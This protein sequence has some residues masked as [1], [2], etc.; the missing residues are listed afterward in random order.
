MK[1]HI[2]LLVLLSALTML[3]AALT[4]S[5]AADDT[6]KLGIGIVDATGLRL[7]ESPSTDS[8]V[9]NSAYQD[10]VVVVLADCGEWYKVI[11]NLDVGY[12]YKEYVIF[13]AVENADLGEAEVN[14][15]L[16]NL[17]AKPNSSAEQL[18]QLEQGETVNIIGLNNGWYK[19]DYITVLGWTTG[20]IRSDL[21]DLTEYPYENRASANVPKF[22]R[23]GYSIG[24][25]PSPAA[26]NGGSTSQS[27]TTSSSSAGEA[28]V[29]KAKEY[30]GVPYVYGGSSPSGFDCSGYVQYVMRACGYTIGRGTDSQYFDGPGTLV[31]KDELI[32]GD[33]VFFAG[34]YDTTG[35]SHV[36]IYIGDGNFIHSSSSGCVKITD[37]YSSYYVEHYYG[38]RRVF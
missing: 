37:L 17:R 34:T 7:R 30:L 3:L 38:A 1:K 12:M 9:I 31:S 11:Y 22:F 8:T 28:I 23:G 14:C 2:R 13:K 21:L 4:I 16:V 18:K 10:D 5:A 36:G 33:L 26:L 32:P 27:G 15:A 24:P 19:V 6:V 29:A 35:T 20:Y 25:A